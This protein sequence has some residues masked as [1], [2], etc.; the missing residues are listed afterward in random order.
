MNFQLEKLSKAELKKVAAA[1]KVK[2]SE[3]DSLSKII[4]KIKEQRGKLIHVISCVNC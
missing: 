3:N 4:E 1:E 2:L